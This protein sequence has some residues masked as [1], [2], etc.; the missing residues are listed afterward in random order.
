MPVFLPPPFATWA[1]PGPWQVSHSCMFAGLPG[2]A[3]L[4]WIDFR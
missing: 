2:I 4:A 1:E 3:F